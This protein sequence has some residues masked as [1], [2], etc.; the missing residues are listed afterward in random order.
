MIEIEHHLFQVPLTHLTVT[1]LDSCLRHKLGHAGCHLIDRFHFIVYKIDLTTAFDLTQY[2]FPDQHLV[3]FGNKCF[4]CQAFLGGCRD[5]RHIPDAAESHIE[6]ARYRCRREGE[7]V[8][9]GPHRF[10][11]LLVTYA[12][13]VF[14]VDN[15]QAE[16]PDFHRTL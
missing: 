16:I 4:D 9:F 5:Q 8:D 2:G 10:Q 6:R 1:Y 3:P 13:A 7:D 12:K 15:D 14:F 11:S